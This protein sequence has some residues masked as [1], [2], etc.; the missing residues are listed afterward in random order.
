MR[1]DSNVFSRLWWVAELTREGGDY[2]LTER[3][4]ARQSIA[5]QVF[6][7]RYSWHRPAVVA[8]LDELEEASPRVVDRVTRDLVGALGTLAL[9]ALSLHEL[10]ALVRALRVAAGA[11]VERQGRS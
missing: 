10:R 4:F 11:D 5:I 7:R 2:A 3:V 1:H 8:L 9:E 6:V